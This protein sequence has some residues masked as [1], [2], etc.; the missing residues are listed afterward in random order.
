MPIILARIDDR[1]VHGQIVQGWLKAVSI[2]TL[3]VVSG[4]AAC[5]KMQQMLMA[6][7]VPYGI[8]LDVKTLKEA[9]NALVSGQYSKEK[10]MLLAAHPSY[11]LH[12]M[13]NGVSFKSLNVGGMHFINGKR[14]LLAN[15]YVD[16]KDIENLYKIYSNGIEIED[17]ILPE[18]ERVNMIPLIEK[19][20]S[21][22]RGAKK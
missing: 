10:V 21:L 3:L 19:E 13:E 17:R 9:T 18:D 14:Q 15:I 6:M 1:L 4:V 20:Y 5:D 16:D 2:D 22:I 8:R 7:A 12:M 11:I